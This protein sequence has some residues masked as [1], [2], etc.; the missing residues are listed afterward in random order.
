MATKYTFE[1]KFADNIRILNSLKFSGSFLEM[2]F[3]RQRVA[4][5]MVRDTV[6]SVV[7]RVS[8]ARQSEIE[9]DVVT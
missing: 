3:W 2:L 7:S 5:R 1:L 6:Y 4:D 9:A 8:L